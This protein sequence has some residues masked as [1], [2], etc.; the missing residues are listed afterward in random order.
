MKQILKKIVFNKNFIFWL[1]ICLS[2]IFY[3]YNT[4][5]I[6]KIELMSELNI[7]NKV[8]LLFVYLFP[9]AFFDKTMLFSFLIE[10]AYLSLIFYILTKYIDYIFYVF[11]TSLVTRLK[12]NK[13]IK[14]LLKMNLVY[15]LIV[16][17]IYI[18]LF[19]LI[20]FQKNIN[21]DFSFNIILI[22][23]IKYLINVLSL[24]VY[25]LIYIITNDSFLSIGI[26]I[27][28]DLCVSIIIRTLF[29]INIMFLK[30]S[31]LLILF[32]IIIIIFYYKIIVNL[33]ERR[34]I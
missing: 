31:F 20:M 16:L 7:S 15:A 33:F 3:C 13:I 8:Y 9:C 11:Q 5:L 10:V 19:L 29:D 6:Y 24:D 14:Y 27:L 25:L 2:I 26:M 32:L 17:T 1:I 18:L 22:V 28:Q 21:F 30:F 12:R 4:L 23:I 34:D